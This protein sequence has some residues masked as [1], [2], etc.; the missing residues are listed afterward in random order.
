MHTH[1]HA[2][3]YVHTRTCTYTYTL[4]H[5]LTHTRA[6]THTH[7]HTHKFF[8]M[9]ARACLHHYLSTI[10]RSRDQ[11]ALPTAHDTY[12]LPCTHIT[13]R[14]THVPHSSYAALITRTPLSST[15]HAGN[16]IT[17]LPCATLVTP[18]QQQRITL[19]PLPSRS[20]VKRH[21]HRSMLSIATK[22]ASSIWIKNT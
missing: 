19:T 21:R 17:E 16:K 7:T 11:T 13:L 9:H 1:T 8:P 6:H 14:P 12:S 4:T 18:E 22:W 10:A 3:T 20:T 15:T 2:H 5:T